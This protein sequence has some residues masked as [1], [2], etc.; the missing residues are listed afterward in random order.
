MHSMDGFRSTTSEKISVKAR[1]IANPYGL[2]QIEI[3]QPITT[4]EV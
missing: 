4:D 1:C 3:G 2:A